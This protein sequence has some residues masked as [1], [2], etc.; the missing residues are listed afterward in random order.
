[1]PKSTH[2]PQY[3]AF[4]ELLMRMRD[5]RGVTQEQVGKRLRMTQSMVSKVERGERRLDVVELWRWCGA[6]GTTLTEF[7]AKLEKVIG[8]P[9][10][11]SLPPPAAAPSGGRRKASSRGDGRRRG[12]R[13]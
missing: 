8:P 12:K 2:T 11:P 1:M 13:R 3:D 4:R 7:A 9:P 5:E 10:S 6:I